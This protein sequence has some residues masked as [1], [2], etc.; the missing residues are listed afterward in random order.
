M[1]THYFTNH[2]TLKPITTMIRITQSLTLV[3]FLLLAL[4]SCKDTEDAKPATGAYVIWTNKPAKKFDRIEVSIDG[5]PAGTLTKPYNT[6]PLDIKPSC[7]SKEEGALIH[8]N[9]TAGTHQID[10]DAFLNGEKVDGWEGN[11]KIEA[12]QCQKGLLPE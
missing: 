3:F 1:L 11:F 2:F 7:S 8:L 9:L 4:T 12:N 6:G 5:K 10:A